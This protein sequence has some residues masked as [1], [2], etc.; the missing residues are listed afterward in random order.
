MFKRLIGAGGAVALA[1]AYATPGGT[2][3]QA[4]T[5]AEMESLRGGHGPTCDECTSDFVVV[6]VCAHY[7]P[8]D[9]CHSDR[10][11]EFQVIEDS[12][13]LSEEGICLATMSQYADG[14]VWNL[15]EDT[16]CTSN[17]PTQLQAIVT[18]YYGSECLTRTAY[19][20]CQ[21][22]SGVCNGELVDSVSEKPGIECY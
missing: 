12:C 6:H 9:Y 21:K 20:R 5:R 7:S 4:L 22:A 11:I 2:S 3:P 19:A 15:R 17:N 1:L 10:C 14:A 16:N 13:F 8:T 18:H